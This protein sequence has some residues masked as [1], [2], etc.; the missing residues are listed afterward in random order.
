M[1]IEIDINTDGN[2]KIDAYTVGS[3]SVDNTTYSTSLVISSQA[4]I[5]DWSPERFSDLKAEHIELLLPLA[6]ELVILGTGS[7]I[8]FP[9]TE[10]IAPLISRQIGIEIMDTGAACRSFNFLTGEGRQVVA[11]L[12]MLE[13]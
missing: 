9:T 12:F 5:D 3:I 4:I 6:P 7:E 10:I 2:H 1:K 8:C 11:A 13:E